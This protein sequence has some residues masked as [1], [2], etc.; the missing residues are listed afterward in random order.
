MEEGW[1]GRKRRTRSNI[2]S[3]VE[4]IGSFGGG[5]ASA[6]CWPVPLFWPTPGCGP[7][8][9]ALISG[10]LFCPSLRLDHQGPILQGCLNFGVSLFNF[11]STYDP[12]MPSIFLTAF[13]VLSLVIG[14]VTNEKAFYGWHTETNDQKFSVNSFCICFYSITWIFHCI[15]SSFKK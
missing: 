9:R 15:S 7:W 12:P 11:A 10:A 4:D 13:F 6:S 3:V 5:K 1:G 14:P 8:P 2:R